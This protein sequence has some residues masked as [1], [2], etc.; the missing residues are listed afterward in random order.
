MTAEC[1]GNECRTSEHHHPGIRH[2]ST[3]HQ[4]QHTHEK[5]Q[6]D[7]GSCHSAGQYMARSTLRRAEVAVAPTACLHKQ[8][9]L[10]LLACLQ[11][12]A[13]SVDGICGPRAKRALRNSRSQAVKQSG[14]AKSPTKG[15]WRKS[16]AT[17]G[18]EIWFGVSIRGLPVRNPT[19]CGSG[20]YPAWTIR[21]GAVKDF[22]S[23]G[24]PRLS[25][26]D[27]IWTDDHRFHGS[28]MSSVRIPLPQIHAV[29][30]INIFHVIHLWHCSLE[31]YCCA[32]H[33]IYFQRILSN[34]SLP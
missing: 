2:R 24:H 19:T 27:V 31:V 4:A 34:K 17:P 11:V 16:R 14:F 8:P 20:F 18:S 22:G 29:C 32:T 3:A 23:I 15:R 6:R 1:N 13:V 26:E 30:A 7:E 10:V 21:A 33:S 28:F 25:F 12:C 9:L 5:R